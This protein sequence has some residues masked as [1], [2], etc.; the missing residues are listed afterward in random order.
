MGVT[1]ESWTRDIADDALPGHVCLS[2]GKVVGYCFGVKATGEI[3]VL[4]LLPEFENRGIGKTLL[5]KMVQDFPQPWLHPAFP[6]LLVKSQDEVL[7]FLQTPRMVVDG[8]EFRC[9]Q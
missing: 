7:W 9:G 8:H 5:N 2:G 1:L 6:G 4:A 3:A